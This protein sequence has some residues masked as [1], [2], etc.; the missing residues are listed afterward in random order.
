MSKMKQIDELTDKLVP[1]V[2]HKIY[3]ELQKVDEL[4]SNSK[5]S[6]NESKARM[7]WLISLIPIT[8]YDR[9]R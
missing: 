6:T 7:R 3:K 5:I 2:L 9:V 4:H 8:K 1:Q